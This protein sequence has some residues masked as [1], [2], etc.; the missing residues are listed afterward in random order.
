[1]LLAPF[2][3]SRNCDAVSSLVGQPPYVNAFDLDMENFSIADFSS[4]WC[5]TTTPAV[6]F[7]HSITN[8]D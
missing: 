8:R 2:V 7:E 5:T 3:L 1:M 6:C 4:L